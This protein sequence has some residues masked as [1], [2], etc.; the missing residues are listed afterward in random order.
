[1]T[2]TAISNKCPLFWINI[3]PIYIN[4]IIRSRLWTELTLINIIKFTMKP[5]M[6]INIIKYN[7]TYNSVILIIVSANLLSCSP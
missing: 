1:M 6:L 5:I 7:D 4:T 2:V 3:L